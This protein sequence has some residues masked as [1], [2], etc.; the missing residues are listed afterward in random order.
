MRH[1]NIRNSSQDRS[2]F[3][4]ESIFLF[5]HEF[6]FYISFRVSLPV[7]LLRANTIPQQ[8]IFILILFVCVY[9]HESNGVSLWFRHFVLDSRTQWHMPF[10]VCFF[11]AYRALGC[12]GITN[13]MRNSFHFVECKKETHVSDFF[14]FDISFWKMWKMWKSFFT[15]RW[16]V[17]QYKNRQAIIICL[18]QESIWKQE[19]L[20]WGHRIFDFLRTNHN[21]TWYSWNSVAFTR[22][23][24]LFAILRSIPFTKVQLW[25]KK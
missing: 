23:E 14:C 9:Q 3:H 17:I 10:A 13:A 18:A 2:L 1:K 22:F 12:N 21:S 6:L 8:M 19:I 16:D 7:F 20:C 15:E 5:L 24:V 4:L 11:F 25:T